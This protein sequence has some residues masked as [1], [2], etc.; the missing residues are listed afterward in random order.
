MKKLYIWNWV[1][2]GYNWTYASTPEEAWNYATTLCN[3]TPDLK[4]FKVCTEQEAA[5]YWKNFPS[6]D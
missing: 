6:L 4:T 1:E 5:V 2:G 3:L